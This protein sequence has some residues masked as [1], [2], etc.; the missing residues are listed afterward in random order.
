VTTSAFINPDDIANTIPQEQSI[1]IGRVWRD[2]SIPGPCVIL[3]HEEIAYDITSSFPTVSTFFENPELWDWNKLKNQ[4]ENLGNI[5][6]IIGKKDTSSIN[7]L[8]PCDLQ[9]IKACGVT[10]AVSLIE[11]VIEEKADGDPDLAKLIRNDIAKEIGKNILN[12]KPGSDD[13]A[14]LKINLM[15]KNMWSQYMEVGLGPDAEVFTK[16]QI[17]SSVGHLDKIGIHPMSTWN[18]PEPEI[19]LAV[20]SKGKILGVTLGNDVNLRDV[21]GRSAL[22]L[23]RA[24]DNNGSCSI[25]PFIRV[26]D[27]SFDI[28]NVKQAIVSLAIDGTDSYHLEGQSHMSEISREPEELVKQVINSHH[29]Y[30]DGLM[31]F[32]GT[33]FTPIDDRDHAGH[34][35]THKVGDVV[36]ISSPKIGTLINIV[37]HTNNIPS[38]DFGVFD[39]MQNLSKRKLI[40]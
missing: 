11:R 3:V 1:L 20:N 28:R 27:E 35:F 12:I 37:D 6:S 25:G 15:K 24:K 18:N 16:A 38:W 2:G 30:P 13:A 4:H 40:R 8:A 33:M 7:L 26:F 23:G 9:A 5:N 10:F 31:L 32:L 34:G 19:V 39:L 29:Q 22:L 17:L 36:K 14:K 21:E